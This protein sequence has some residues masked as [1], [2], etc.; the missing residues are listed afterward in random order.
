MNASYG[1]STQV[2]L[3]KHMLAIDT[4]TVVSGPTRRPTA[5]ILWASNGRPLK[6]RDTRSG[7]IW[8]GKAAVVA[9]H[10]LRAMQA[11]DCGLLSLNFEPGHP[12]FRG[13]CDITREKGMLP[14]DGKSLLPC[15]N[16]VRNLVMSSDSVEM[17]R[18]ATFIARLVLPSMEKAVP[19]DER[20]AVAIERLEEN[21]S[22]PPSLPELA[23]SVGL[24]GRYLSDL[25]VDQV[26]LAARSYIVWRRYRR[27]LASLHLPHNLSDI[28]Q[29]VGF[30]DQAQMARTFV[31]FFGFAPSRLRE[32]GSIR[33]HGG[34][35]HTSRALQN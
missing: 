30:Y 6:M 19:G 9:P 26:G 22:K 4:P 34:P 18:L 17:D 31:E 5:V 14:L 13:L 35:L 12:L 32:Q 3:C 10:F 7:A 25:F 1:R 24:S 2:H 15:S 16:D 23:R 28:A 33:F 20:V 27:A 8:E 11:E 21:L 29:S